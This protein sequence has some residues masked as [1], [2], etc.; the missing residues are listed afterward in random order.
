VIEVRVADESVF[1]VDL[2]GGR[3]IPINRARVHQDPI[4]DEESR[5]T[6]PWSLAPIRAENLDL[7]PTVF[8]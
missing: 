8:I 5:G 3:Q 1:D 6:L 2:L 7:H 4:V